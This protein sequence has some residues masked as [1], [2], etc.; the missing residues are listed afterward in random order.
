MTGSGVDLL[1]RARRA[2]DRVRSKQRRIV[3]RAPGLIHL[4]GQLAKQVSREAKSAMGR[5]N[6][7]ARAGSPAINAVMGAM[8]RIG[9]RFFH[10]SP[11]HIDALVSKHH[12]AK[13]SS[14]GI[15]LPRRARRHRWVLGLVH[16]FVVRCE[17]L[18][19]D[20]E[21]GLPDCLC[22]AGPP[23]AEL[24]SRSWRFPITWSSAAGPPP[25]RRWRFVRT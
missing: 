23:Y 12:L 25:A 22:A 17:Q 14:T 18:A 2:W 11:R 16:V 20:H 6:S 4:D 8:P 24:A 10:R 19:S 7:S 21:S 13:L 1:A 15:R 3:S 9:L 5:S